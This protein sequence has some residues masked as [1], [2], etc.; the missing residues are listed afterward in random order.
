ML[1]NRMWPLMTHQEEYRNPLEPTTSMLKAVLKE[2]MT[3][4]LCNLEQMAFHITVTCLRL[5][6]SHTVGIER[7]EHGSERAGNRMG[8]S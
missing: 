1:A 4:K 7:E 2:K 5:R 8:K 3:G 6:V